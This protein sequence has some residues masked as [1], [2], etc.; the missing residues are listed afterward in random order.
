MSNRA[1]VL[2]SGGLDSVAALCWATA[3][4]TELEA[5]SFEYGQPNRNQEIPAAQRSAEARGVPWRVVGLSDA[6]RPEK[7]AGI[8][9]GVPDHAPSTGIDKAFVPG[10][11]ALFATVAFAHACT[12][13]PTGMIHVVMGA[14]IEDQDGFPDCK[15]VNLTQLATGLQACFGRTEGFVIRTPWA[16]KTK[17]QI[18]YAVKPDAEALGVV[19][20]SYSCYRQDGPCLRCSACVKREAAFTDQG[21]QDLSQR[22]HMHGGDAARELR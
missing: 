17:A 16:H 9:N 20:R 12:W 13:W 3:R 18:L 14:C 15:P 5:I 6:M 22:T 19:Q 7:P 4:Y 8:L 1:V 10:R 11:N 2:L 21:I